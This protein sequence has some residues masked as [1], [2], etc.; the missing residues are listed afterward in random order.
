MFVVTSLPTGT[1][2]G[3]H[4]FTFTFSSKYCLCECDDGQ[5]S[6]TYIGGGLGLKLQINKS[7]TSQAEFILLPGTPNS[8]DIW[9]LFTIGTFDK[10]LENVH[11]IKRGEDL[12]NLLS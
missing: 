9:F 8:G 10:I 2:E 11:G 1:E 7:G 4:R 6:I 12:L 3:P 5:K